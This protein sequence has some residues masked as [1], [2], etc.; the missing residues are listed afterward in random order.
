[1]V[2]AILGG[3]GAW[4]KVR[5]CLLIY[6]IF[7]ILM[8]VAQGVLVGFWISARTRANEWLKGRML[9]LLKSYEGPTKTDDISAGWNT[10]F[11]TAECCGVNAQYAS[12]GTNN[13]FSELDVT[14]W[15]SDRSVTEV[16]PATCCQGVTSSTISNY[17]D[18]ATCTQTPKNFYTA[19]CYD[20]VKE[21]IYTFS[22][23]I[24]ITVAITFAVEVTAIICSC[25][26]MS[27]INKIT[28]A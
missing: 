28:H 24:L 1:M 2:V 25:L 22:L 11:M 10:L 26:V 21:Y 18:S 23:M 8:I 12:G 16:I 14:W 9:D 7:I 20:R 13:D 6:V 19:G 17:V 4:N 3:C 27:A 15:N 5:P